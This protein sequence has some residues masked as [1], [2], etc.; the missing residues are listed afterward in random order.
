MVEG[1]Y[2]RNGGGEIKEND[3]EGE[4]KYDMFIYCKNFCKC[5]IV[6]LPSTI[7]KKIWK[8]TGKKK[9]EALN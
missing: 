5:H 4:F 3:E 8:R 1:I 9:E 2:F 6:P 7:L